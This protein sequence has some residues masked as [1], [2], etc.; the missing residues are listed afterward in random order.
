MVSMGTHFF[1]SATGTDL[2]KTWLTAG[3]AASCGARGVAVRSLK[4]V[5]SGYDV[6]RHEDSDAAKIGFCGTLAIDSITTWR[7]NAP[8]SPVLSSAHE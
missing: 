1:I 3:V 7:F 6:E 5:M 2:G 4:P 8:L